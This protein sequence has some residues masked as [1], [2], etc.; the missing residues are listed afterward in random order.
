[1][2]TDQI[3]YMDTAARAAV[4]AGDY[5]Q[6]LLTAM[7]IR[8]GHV[9]VDI[10]CGPGIDLRSL[11]AAR[12]QVIGVDR[13]PAMIA[14]ARR[15]VPGADVRQGDAHALPVADGSADRAR[16]DRVLQHLAQPDAVLAEIFRVLRPGGVV[17]LAEP[18]WDTLTVAADDIETSRGFARFTAGRV[19][20]STVGRE[21]ARMAVRAGFELLSVEAVPVVFRDFEIA[22][23][24][25][26]LTRNSARA[27][28]AAQLREDVAASW[29]SSLA[30]PRDPFLASFLCYLVTAE[31][32]RRD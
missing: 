30:D 1:M 27:V 31:R 15:R 32:P 2:T 18:D 16:T 19:R 28:E 8:P 24:I 11:L 10:G 23:Q 25:L 4:A 13:D 7:D 21:L 14:E 20:N 29:L 12:A 22:D 6:R 26:G 5:K 17:G 9:V 3:A